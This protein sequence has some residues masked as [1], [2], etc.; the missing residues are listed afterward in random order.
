MFH[1][2]CKKSA[3][4]GSSHVLTSLSDLA[5][6]GFRNKR[7]TAQPLKRTQTPPAPSANRCAAVHTPVEGNHPQPWQSIIPETVGPAID[8][9]ILNRAGS[10]AVARG[11]DP[12]EGHSLI[13][14]DHQ[15]VALSWR[16]C[17]EFNRGLLEYRPRILSRKGREWTPLSVGKAQVA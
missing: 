2:A 8:S 7:A 4:H 11:F 15:A 12:T 14:R 6:G 1:F 10:T 16:Q 13:N 5:W 9:S 3:T 17:F